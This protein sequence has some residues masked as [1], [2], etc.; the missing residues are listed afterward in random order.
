MESNEQNKLTNKTDSYR[1]QAD[2]SGVWGWG[3]VGM[4]QRRKKKLIDTDNSVV[5][6]GEGVG[7]GGRG[8]WGQK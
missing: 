1:K 3:S 7:G 6:V 5:I 4:E 8:H 2:S